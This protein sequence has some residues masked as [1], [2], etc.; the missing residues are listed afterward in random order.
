MAPYPEQ[1]LVDTVD[2]M[3]VR[4]RILNQQLLTVICMALHNSNP[5]V[6]HLAKDLQQ[7]CSG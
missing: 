5:Q 1:N 2:L 4:K 6:L 3:E 7:F